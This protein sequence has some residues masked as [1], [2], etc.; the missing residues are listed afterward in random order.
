L[1]EPKVFEPL[2]DKI[3][4]RTN[5]LEPN[6]EKCEKML[7]EQSDK[8]SVQSVARLAKQQRIKKKRERKIRVICGRKR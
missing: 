7:T 6:G 8:K 4:E 2:G 1:Q 5:G 3:F